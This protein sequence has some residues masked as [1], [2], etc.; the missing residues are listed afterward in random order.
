MPAIGSLRFQLDDGFD[1]GLALQLVAQPE[2]EMSEHYGS[3]HL[4]TSPSTPYVICRFN[5]AVDESD[6]VRMGTALLQEAL[7]L[8]SMLGR[9][10]LSVKNTKDEYIAWWRNGTKNTLSFTST[11]TFSARVGTPQLVVRDANGDIIPSP[12]VTPQHHLA[13]RF[14]RQAQV[15]DDLYDSFRSMY[16]A[17]ESLL[18]SRHP[19]GN[20]QEIQWLHRAL[21][22]SLVDLQLQAICPAGTVDCVPYLLARIYKNARLPLFHAKGGRTYFAPGGN[23]ADRVIVQSGLSVLAEI[24]IRMAAAWHSTRRRGG[25]VNL[26]LFT[27]GFR[28]QAVG[29]QVVFSDEPTDAENLK[30][31]ERTTLM[32]A[33]GVSTPGSVSEFFDGAPRTNVTASFDVAHLGG[34]KGLHAIYVVKDAVPLIGFTPDTVIGVDG[35][36]HIV[37]RVFVQGRNSNQPK[38]LFS[39]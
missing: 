16:L 30:N 37:A 24:V 21:N 10:D 32:A 15:S 9:A 3:S 35:L 19:K 7:D 2:E 38:T 6:T 11:T 28:D 8:H 5:G 12:V 25:W 4:M 36:D 14:F 26:K 17:F 29:C 34:R 27:A 22:A 39:R 31:E 1:S 18:S 23:E 13:F 33:R 20:E